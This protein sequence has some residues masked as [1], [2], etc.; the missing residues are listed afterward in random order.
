MK[1]AIDRRAFLKTSSAAGLGILGHFTVGGSRA[2]PSDTMV[3]A[4]MGVNSRGRV[5]GQSFA[6]AN[7][8]R[9]KTLCDVD[10]RAIGVARQAIAD[11]SDSDP[12]GEED[13]RRV[14]EDPDIDVLV[15]AAPDHW[16]APAAIM[17]LQAGKHVYVEKPCGYNPHEGEMLVEAQATYDRVVQMGNQQRA[18]AESQQIIQ[19]I[20]EGLIG[21][22]YYGRSWYANTRGSIGFGT[23]APVPDWLNYDLW[24]G[25]APRVQYRDNLIHYNWHWFWHWGTGEICNNGT[26]EIDIC[27]WALGV[28]YPIKVTSSG[29]RF[30]YQDDW[31]FYDTQVASFEFPDGKMLTWDGRSCNGKFE[32][33]MGRGASIHG[34]RGTVVMDRQGYVVYDQNN[35]EIWKRMR[36]ATVSTMDVVGGGGLT[37]EHIDNFLR[38][39]R[40]GGMQFSPIDEGHKSTLLCHLGNIAQ[41]TGRTLHCDPADGKILGDEEAMQMWR[42]AYEPGWEVRV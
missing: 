6:K 22:V 25:P 9:V 10:A 31:E 34:E 8:C 13:I 36:S 12:G 16:H 38:V 28:D 37:D 3:A 41:H 29:G 19:A 42:R 26:H 11:V 1:P 30:A 24:Q 35:T 5:L 21:R 4:V 40:E 18:S 23:E 14:L 20:R 7:G 39:I 15:I 17:A 32:N 27:R 33:G 2:A